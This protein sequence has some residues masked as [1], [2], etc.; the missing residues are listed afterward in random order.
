ME[1]K[2]KVFFCLLSGIAFPFRFYTT[3]SGSASGGAQCKSIIRSRKKFRE[4]QMRKKHEVPFPKIDISS[5]AAWI[6]C[7]SNVIYN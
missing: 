1:S 6:A 5:A 7:K 3:E 4:N 2:V